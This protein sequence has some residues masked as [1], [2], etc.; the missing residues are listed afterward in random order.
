MPWPLQVWG[1]EEA[2]C[3]L[4]VLWYLRPLPFKDIHG[5]LLTKTIVLCLGGKVIRSTDTHSTGANADR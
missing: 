1:C 5:L 4:D 2:N 3:G